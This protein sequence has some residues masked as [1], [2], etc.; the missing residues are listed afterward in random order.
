VCA[1]AQTVCRLFA[2][3][4]GGW[5]ER[6]RGVLRLNE[7]AEGARL[8]ARVAG[9]LRVVL[10]TKLWPA[11]VVERAGAR[12]L[13]ITAADAAQHVKLFLVMVSTNSSSA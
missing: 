2:W 4:A 11:M 6:G 7:G 9:S 13:R 3:E 1:C 12:S 8:V 10:N 5:R